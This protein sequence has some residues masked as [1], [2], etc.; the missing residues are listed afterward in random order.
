MTFLSYHILFVLLSAAV[1]VGVFTD[2]F[3]Y[4]IP[5]K[6]NLAL[7]LGF[8]MF[9]FFNPNFTWEIAG[10]HT[11]T[12]SIILLI[13]FIFFALGFFGGGD[14]KLISAI[15][16]WLGPEL[17]LYF[18]IYTMIIG[19][20]VSVFFLFW[21]CTTEFNFY[22]KFS[23]LKSLY[24]GPAH[25]QDLRAT[26]RGIPYAIAIAVGYFIILPQHPTFIEILTI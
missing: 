2:I 12:A 18:V 13:S 23:I 4:M 8:Y 25:Q 15:S 26:K 19:G 6:L 22:H 21:R 7:F 20:L 3:H 5:N 9:A 14:A 1:L 24:Y 17:S 10:Y 16:L 11:L